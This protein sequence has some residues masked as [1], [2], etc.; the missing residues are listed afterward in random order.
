[1]ERS[2]NYITKQSEAILSYIEGLG[3][4]HVT[5]AQIAEHFDEIN[6]PI[7]R[8]TI[9][10]HLDR[11][12]ESGELRR[13]ITDG[14][15]GAC[16]QRVNKKENCDLHLHLKCEECGELTHLECDALQEIQRHFFEEH[17]FKID[18]LKTVFYGKCEKCI[19]KK[20]IFAR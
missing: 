12:T 10:R 13:Y 16:Y 11:L 15:S 8:T 2:A 9:Y 20:E 17:A 1:M 6:A 3:K 7:G 5:A 4:S 19:S 14:S 18:V